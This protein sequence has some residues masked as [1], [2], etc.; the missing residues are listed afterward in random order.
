MTREKTVGNR[1]N[2]TGSKPLVRALYPIMYYSPFMVAGDPRGQRTATIVR[3]TQ[4]ED[5]AFPIKV[6]RLEKL[7]LWT[8]LT[9]TK[10]DAGHPCDLRFSR[11]TLLTLGPSLVNIAVS[12][13]VMM[14]KI[15]P[16][17]S[18]SS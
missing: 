5:R 11:P 1:K 14:G 16:T 12:W 13:R 17:M 3:I 15:V 4:H 2:V 10:N 9:R 7:P 6:N 18:L 8:M